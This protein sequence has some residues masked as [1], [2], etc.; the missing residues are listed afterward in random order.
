MT[1]FKRRNIFA[2]DRHRCVACR[3]KKYQLIAHHVIPEPQGG[4]DNEQNVVTLCRP[5]H[6]AVTG[7]KMYQAIQPEQIRALCSEYL[8]RLFGD[9]WDPYSPEWRALMAIR[10]AALSGTITERERE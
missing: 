9:K 4:A 5:C 7:F 2:R 3:A 8:R 1:Q 10:D 6:L